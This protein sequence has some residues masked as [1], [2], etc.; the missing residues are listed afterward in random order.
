MTDFIYLVLFL[1]AGFVL[2]RLAYNYGWKSCER[3][4]AEEADEVPSEPEPEQANSPSLSTTNSIMR[5]ILPELQCK[6]LEDEGDKVTVRYQGETYLFTTED[7]RPL[8]WIY[9]LGWFEFPEDDI[10]TLAEVKKI[11]NQ[12]NIHSPLVVT[13]NHD[14]EEHKI[15]VSSKYTMYLTPDVPSP[16]SFVEHIFDSCARLRHQ[17]HSELEYALKK[18]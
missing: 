10:D 5:S 1:C 18:E 12:A 6:L 14:E 16:Q 15:S 2:Y 8:V 3:A 11:I 7:D 9:D 17:F 4:L 13:Y